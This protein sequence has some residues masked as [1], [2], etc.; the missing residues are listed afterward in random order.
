MVARNKPYLPLKKT[1]LHL[2]NQLMTRALCPLYSTAKEKYCSIW[3][4]KKNNIH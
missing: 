1:D 3:G 4:Q 2:H